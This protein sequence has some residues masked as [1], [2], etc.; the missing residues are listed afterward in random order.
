[1]ENETPNY[2]VEYRITLSGAKSESEAED[3]SDVIEKAMQAAMDS[4][5]AH[6][7]TVE[8]YTY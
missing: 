1:M 6:W 5:C 4:V 8:V 2:A 7:E 3:M